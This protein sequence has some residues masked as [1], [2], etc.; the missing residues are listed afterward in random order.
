MTSWLACALSL[1]LFTL[2]VSNQKQNTIASIRQGA[3][4]CLVFF[5][6]HFRLLCINAIY[7]SRTSS[8]VSCFFRM[9]AWRAPAGSRQSRL[10]SYKRTFVLVL[11]Q[12]ISTSCSETSAISNEWTSLF[13][14]LFLISDV[15]WNNPKIDWMASLF[16]FAVWRH[17]SKENDFERGAKLRRKGGGIQTR[18]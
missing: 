18:I 6:R 14:Y 17:R 10:V 2:Q 15:F 4:F 16:W 7:T 12:T 13:I 8:V 3:V 11:M 9:C 5:S 1:S